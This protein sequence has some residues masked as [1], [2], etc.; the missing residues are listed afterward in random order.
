[1]K[2]ILTFIL[3]SALTMSIF[4]T[5]Q[6]I[7]TD[8]ATKPVQLMS[9]D[10]YGFD[11]R[12][13]IA[14]LEMN[15]VETS[16][17]AFTTVTAEDFECVTEPGQPRLP[18]NREIIAVPYGAD[19]HLNVTTG[20]IRELPLVTPVI[21]AQP[22]LSK[23]ERIE[24]A[25]FVID[26]EIYASGNWMN[27]EIATVEELGILRG[28]R[29]F[30]LTVRPVDYNPASS[31]IR[32]YSDVNVEVEFTGANIAETRHQLERTYSHYFEPVFQSS[33]LNYL[34]LIHRDELTQ[35][36]VKYVIVYDDMFE[37]QLQPF[38]EWKTE[39]GFTVVAANT[40]DI[41]NTT[42]AI[43]NYLQDLYD[44]GTTTNPAPSFVLFVGD[45]GQIPAYNGSTGSHITD[46]NYVKLDG[47]DY[48]PDM[49]YG[50]FS[51]NNAGELQPQIDKTL[52]FEKYEMPDPS[53]LGEV[54]MIA[55][56][57]SSHGSTWA[58]GQINYGTT[59]YFNEDHGIESHTYLY[60]QSGNNESNII[61]NISNGV[62][63]VNYT[64]HGGP[65]SWSDPE[66]TI[67]DINSLNNDGKYP[68]IV[69]NCCSTSEFQVT[70]CFSEAWLRA[71]DKGAIG[72]IG[73]T[74]S[75]Y[76][77]EDYYWG[78]G[79]GSIVTNPTYEGTGRGVYDG[80]FHDHGETEADWFVTGG[81]MIMCGNLA[82]VEGGGDQNYYWE[83]YTLMGEPSITPYLGVPAEN[84]IDHNEQILIGMTTF[85]VSADPYSYVCLSMDG[86][87]HS[88][89]LV[90]DS[91]SISLDLVPFTEPGNAQLVITAQNRQPVITTVQIVPS[92][93]AYLLAD[94]FIYTDNNNNLPQYG[95]SA[96]LSLPLTNVG[97][98]AASNVTVTIVCDDEYVSI[99]DG[100]ESFDAISTNE[101][102]TLEDAFEIDIAANIP[103]QHI[104]AI[105]IL[106]EGQV[107]GS[108]ET[109]E[110]VN[111]ITVNAPNFVIGEMDVFDA[112]GNNNGQLD[113]G[114]TTAISFPI[115]NNGHMD[116]PDVVA[117]LICTNPWITI[118]ESSDEVGGIDI[119][120]TEEA[121]FIVSLSDE[122]PEGTDINLGLGI[123]AGEYEFQ[124]TYGVSISEMIENFENG[125][126][127]YG[128]N[129][130]G[131]VD[132][133][134][135][136]NEVYE[137]DYC[138][139]SGTISH[140]QVSSAEITV[141]ILS[142]GE[143]SFFY[144]VS[145][146]VDYDFLQFYIDGQMM[147]QWS[148]SINWRQVSYDV[149]EGV[150]TFKWTYDKD[151]SESNGSDCGWID[152]IQFPAIPSDPVPIFMVNNQE[153]DFGTVNLGDS[154]TFDVTLYNYGTAEMTGSITTYDGFTV[155]APERK[156]RSTKAAKATRETYPYSV[157]V[158]GS[159]TFTLKFM[160]TEEADYS[161]QI[162][163]TSNDPYVESTE[164]NVI[165]FGEELGAGEPDVPVFVNELK[166]NYPNPFNPETTISFSL[167][168]KSDV[169]IDVFNI[170][171]QK[172]KTLVSGQ[173]EAGSH[174]I[175]WQGKDQ[176]DHQVGSG[177]YFYKMKT[178]RYTSVKKMLLIK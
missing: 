47:N 167:A 119:D 107:N 106:I 144:R 39:M 137:G 86:M 5:Y 138:I 48:F 36:P 173:M 131:N 133:A 63:Y 110:M 35:Y 69:G 108:T 163:L 27:P 2:R 120:G 18:L 68:F 142:D 159:Y 178:G 172:V 58:N 21:P 145:S 113:P 40:D 99:T 19:V 23:S 103:D 25:E 157:P 112:S 166:G 28:M 125:L 101:S 7:D 10:Q 13:H 4:A 62:G 51:A 61:N 155:V 115:T 175:V 6:P 77:D 105:E 73:G 64:A 148:G 109:W 16:N 126:D 38:I 80:L 11:A 95:E 20:D 169:R 161:G 171:G 81:A 1:M 146:E 31:L 24:D 46:L 33:I 129:M 93:G 29:L 104:L 87:T 111:R 164:I 151:N 3:M 134:L 60:P 88:V 135:T 116:S 121:S 71:E 156:T 52:M 162:L 54:V 102:I 176:Y 26:D 149:Q 174:K 84:E 143:M 92:D 85:D 90:D 123:F 152:L 130:T 83:I 12:F 132:W 96:T 50:R 98:D 44:E 124:I 136:E 72:Y 127:L 59:Y 22:S 43:H 14:G 67:P 8:T 76:W 56:M 97:N 66:F 170:L 128:W 140:N 37:D 94:D 42:S 114:E 74:N 153:L 168:A 165:A 160:P 91:G 53:Y 65:T 79:A 150:H 147:D 89:G 78:V 32:V 139:K 154:L 55:G 15:P 45:T 122:V 141:E 41:G 177:V 75:T 17:G 118:D 70:T 9:N 158:A 34:P 30:L 82:V 57:D 100:E 49:Y 117:M